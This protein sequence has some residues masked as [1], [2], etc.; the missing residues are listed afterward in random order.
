MITVVEVMETSPHNFTAFASDLYDVVPGL[1]RGWPSEIPTNLGNG[2]PFV[3]AERD[4]DSER[5]VTSVR[6]NQRFGCISLRIF[7]D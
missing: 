6:Y 5:E 3:L 1:Q 2:Q 4:T 7:N